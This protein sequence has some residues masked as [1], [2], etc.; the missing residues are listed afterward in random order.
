MSRASFVCAATLLALASGQPA[1]P[2]RGKPASTQTDPSAPVVRTQTGQVQGIAE[3][4]VFAF[5]GIPYA[6]PP[7]GPLRWKEPQ[8]APSWQNIRATNSF[9][10]ACI[11]T[12]GLSEANGG[13]P[14]PLSEDCLYLNVWTPKVDAFA[15]LPVM[16]WIHGGAYIFGSGSLDVYNGAPMASKG[17]VV[18]TINYRL[19]QLGFFAHPVLEKESPGGPANFGLL[20]Q[21]AALRWVQ[22][23]IEQF[24]G[25]PRN[26]TIFGQSAGGKSV[27]AL[28][29]SPL[30]RGLFHKAIVMSSP[31]IPDATR[32]KALEAGANAAAAIGLP[33][34]DVTMEQLRAVPAEKMARFKGQDVSSGPVPISGDAVL[35]QSIQDTFADGKEAPVPLMLGNTSDD[36]SVVLAFGIDPADLIKKLGASGIFVKALYPGVRDP[37]ELGRQVARDLVFTMPVRWAADRHSKRAPTWRYYFDYTAVKDRAKFPHGV[38]HGSEI[39]FALDTG[40]VYQYTQTTFTDADRQYARKVSEYC[41]T[42]AR[43]AKPTSIGAPRWLNDTVGQDRTMIFGPTTQLQANF[44]KA[45]LNVFIG[46]T[47]ILGPIL[48]RK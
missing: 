38:P 33:G 30:A 26:V 1:G 16:V 12:P 42:F 32:A 3:R 11:Q 2:P 5:K 22:S 31:V 7:V 41:F 39:V 29:A 10:N 45:R 15:R 27:M 14:G 4:G 25:D 20:D 34:L 21:I 24:G 13:P 18:V 48:A 28:V 36:A 19:G 35:P 43:D 9:G 46:A 47:K 17:A 6:T 44:M 37:A 8:P 40:D 23:N